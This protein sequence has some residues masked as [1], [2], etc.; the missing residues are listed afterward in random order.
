MSEQD[1]FDQLLGEEKSFKEQ[2]GL[3]S[4]E[5][6]KKLSKALQQVEANKNAVAEKYFAQNGN[7]VLQITIKPNGAYSSYIGSKKK[8]KAEFEAKLKEW[9][10]AGLWLGDVNF[11]EYQVKV[12][13]ILEGVKAKYEKLAD[14]KAAKKAKK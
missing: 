10:K 12:S 8:Y 6:N 11:E 1:Q 2:A 5:K 9:Q 4:N 7:K 13:K 3:P 14:A